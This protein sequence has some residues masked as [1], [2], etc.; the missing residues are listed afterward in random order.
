MDFLSHLY[1]YYL[2]YRPTYRVY[3]IRSGVVGK[4]ETIIDTDMEISRT[5]NWD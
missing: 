2:I 3:Q 1:S 4:D 5:T